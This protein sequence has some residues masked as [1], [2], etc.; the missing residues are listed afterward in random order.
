MWIGEGSHLCCGC[1]W[2][3]VPPRNCRKRFFHLLSG[4]LWM[5]ADSLLS[6]SCVSVTAENSLGH[7]PNAYC[8][9]DHRLSLYPHARGREATVGPFFHNRI[10]GPGP[11][12]L[13]LGTSSNLLD[14]HGVV[15]PIYKV[16]ILFSPSDRFKYKLPSWHIMRA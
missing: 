13:L 16:G 10:V 1:S 8:V 9:S 4:M 11:I 2:A 15:F 3:E 7:S 6:R 5:E 12:T 14:T